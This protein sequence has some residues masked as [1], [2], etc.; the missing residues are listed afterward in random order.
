MD[1]HNENKQEKVNIDS[2]F[3]IW[4]TV[5]V[6]KGIHPAY[7]QH[8]QVYVWTHW[9]YEHDDAASTSPCLFKHFPKRNIIVH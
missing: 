6:W 9:K 8:L 2:S 3:P 5:G 4:K 7:F 1:K